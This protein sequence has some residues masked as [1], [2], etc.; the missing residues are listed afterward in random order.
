MVHPPS[1]P[2]GAHQLDKNDSAP[3][4][5]QLVSA[6]SNSD[7]QIPLLQTWPINKLLPLGKQKGAVS[8]NWRSISQKPRAGWGSLTSATTTGPATSVN[9]STGPPTTFKMNTHS[10]PRS[11]P[12]PHVLHYGQWSALNCLSPLDESALTLLLQ[13]HWWFGL[14]SGSPLAYTLPPSAPQSVTITFFLP[15]ARIDL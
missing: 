8:V 10:G 13:T 14:N 1:F 3:A 11:R 12:P 5:S 4:I 2:D 6:H 9:F 15:P 7:T